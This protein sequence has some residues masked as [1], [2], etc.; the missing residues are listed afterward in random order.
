VIK[1]LEDDESLLILS[2]LFNALADP[3]RVKI[4]R[5]LSFAELCVCDIAAIVN[6]SQSA[7]SHQLRYLRMS[8]LVRYRKDGKMAYYSLDDDHVRKLID[9]GLEHARESR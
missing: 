1:K 5:A 7:V 2:D 6:I 9:Q 4:L 8:R 3:T